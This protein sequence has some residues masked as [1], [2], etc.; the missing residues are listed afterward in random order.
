MIPLTLVVSHSNTLS[1]PIIPSYT[2]HDKELQK[3]LE[4]MARKKNALEG[5][6]RLDHA[7][8]AT[9]RSQLE[10]FNKLN[11]QTEE[12]DKRRVK[13]LKA[14]NDWLLKLA[15][16]TSFQDD[17]KR[18]L[19][20]VALNCWGGTGSNQ[21]EEQLEAARYDEGVVRVYPMLKEF[22]VVCNAANIRFPID[23]LIAR[24]TQVLPM[25]SSLLPS[26]LPTKYTLFYSI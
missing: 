1:T 3:E 16:D 13:D 7:T 11:D 8:I 22:E 19:V 21:P 5:Q 14:V 9:L 25:C 17:L 10:A 15:L 18:P 12:T 24:K 23:H 6:A 20:N 26:K 4:A 2:L